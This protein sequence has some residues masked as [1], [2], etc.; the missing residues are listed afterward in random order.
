MLAYIALCRDNLVDKTECFGI[1]RN[2]VVES[3]I[4]ISRLKTQFAVI[5]GYDG[6]NIIRSRSTIKYLYPMKCLNLQTANTK[7]IRLSSG[8][9]FVCEWF[10]R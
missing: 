7:Q 10:S 4:R 3:G 6:N 2:I 8:R 5:P 9:E 1:S